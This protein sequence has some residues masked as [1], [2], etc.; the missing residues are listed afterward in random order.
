MKQY[1]NAFAAFFQRLKKSGIDTSNTLFVFTVDEGDH[2]VGVR[3]TDCD[4]VKTPCVYGTNEVGEI[5][6]NIDTFVMKQFPS[7]AAQFLGAAAPNAFTV[8][9]DDAPTFY[10]SKKGTGGG[11]LA[12]T[13][14]LTREF[15]RE[16]AK[17]TAVNPYTGATD[18]LLV[19]MADQTGMKALHMFTTGDPTRNPSFVFFGDPNY[20]ITDFPSTTCETCINPLF[21]WNHGDIQREIANIWLGFVGRGC[22][23]KVKTTKPGPITRMCGQLSSRS[24]GYRIRTSTTAGYLRRRSTKTRF[25]RGWA[26]TSTR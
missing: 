18:R 3:K 8:H 4:G 11:Q 13:D 22:G 10:L 16:M 17:L 12:Q 23:A 2:F 1:D 26:T 25:R 21:A 24:L 7:L 14:P 6:A 9:G 20:F 5:N 19:R 15:E